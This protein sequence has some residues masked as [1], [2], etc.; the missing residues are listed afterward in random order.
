MRRRRRRRRRRAGR[1]VDLRHPE[2]AAPRGPRRLRGAPA[3][4]CRSATSTGR[5]GATCSTGCT[6]P[7]ETV[8]IALVGKYVDLPD[9]YLSVTEALR[10]GGFAHRA[11]VE[12]V[13]VPSDDLR[14]AGRR[15]RRAGRRGRRARS[16]A[17]SASAASRA[18]S[19]RSGTPARAASRRSGLCLGLQC[20]VI[21]AARILAGLDGANS[22][23]V[24]RAHPAPGD[25]HDG[26]PARRRR[27]RAGHGRHDAPGRLPGRAR[28]RAPWSRRPTAPAR[29]PSGTGT[30]TRSTTPTAT[31]LEEAGLV[32]GGTSPDGTL[33]EFVELPR[34]R[35]PVLRRHPG[36]PGAEEPPDPA[37]P[38][39]RGVRR[40]PRSRYR[41][42]ERL[43]VELPR[44][45][46][47]R[48]ASNR[49][50]AHDRRHGTTSRS[51]QRRTSTRAR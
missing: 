25:L 23:R 34:R 27:R 7:T 21:E 41:A 51:V 35:A 48:R 28:R 30:A 49:E 19:A 2:G 9:A 18:R 24:R 16:R 33:V 32:F 6:T 20:M 36:A 12:I 1:A 50:P 10:A 3:R 31:R 26:R 39:V 17:A 47:R 13:W 14:D 29:C 11:R 46:P 40:G 42:A 37:A 5:C 22:T 45:S 8:R 4:R 15:G 38:A 43:P 44:A